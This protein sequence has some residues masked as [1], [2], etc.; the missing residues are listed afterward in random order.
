V[1]DAELVAMMSVRYVDVCILTYIS[2]RACIH[3]FVLSI[4]CDCQNQPPLS[5]G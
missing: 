2:V 5:I 3:I 4:C 1:V